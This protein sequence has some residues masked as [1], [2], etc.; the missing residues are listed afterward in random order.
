MLMNV[1]NYILSC[2]DTV[3]ITKL[4][5]YFEKLNSMSNFVL[6]RKYMCLNVI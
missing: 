3:L 2:K 1:N 4:C 6:K 5:Q